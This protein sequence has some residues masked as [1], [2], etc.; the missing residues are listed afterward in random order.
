MTY[1]QGWNAAIKAAAEV[2]ERKAY[3]NRLDPVRCDAYVTAQEEIL[4]LKPEAQVSDEAIC[5]H[6][7]GAEVVDWYPADYHSDGLW[8]PLYAH[9]APPVS[10]E[11]VAWM[12]KDGSIV[13]KLN[14]TNLYAKPLYLHPTH[15]AEMERDAAMTFEEWWKK[16]G[17]VNLQQKLIAEE[18]WNA[19]RGS[20]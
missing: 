6:L 20:K 18:A 11:P 10:D 17:Y 8:Q 13:R 1:E 12:L 15:N 16:S 3:E 7:I 2:C 19:A 9:P 5:W 4:A 14:P